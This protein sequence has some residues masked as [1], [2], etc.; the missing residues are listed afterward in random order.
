MLDSGKIMHPSIEARANLD[1]GYQFTAMALVVAGEDLPG[2]PLTEIVPLMFNE[3]MAEEVCKLVN[4]ELVCEC[5]KTEVKENMSTTTKNEAISDHKKVQFMTDCLNSGKSQT[6]CEV[7]CEKQLGSAP[8]SNQEAVMATTCPQCKTAL[9][10]TGMCPNK[11]CQMNKT[12]LPAD[13]NETLATKDRQIAELTEYKAD[14]QKEIEALKEA[15]SKEKATVKNRD[16]RLRQLEESVRDRDKRI[17]QFEKDTDLFRED[18]GKLTQA[19]E[20]AI[21]E[22]NEALGKAA[23]D[24]ERANQE[25]TAR[26]SIQRECGDL[27][28][29]YAKVT[30]EYA[31]L[32]LKRSDDAKTISGLQTESIGYK[33]D[34]QQ[35]TEALEAKAKECER[36]D[37][38]LK[39]AR[40]IFDK[41]GIREVNHEG[42]LVSPV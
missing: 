38:L 30:R 12:Q 37:F 31:D 34:L 33:T 24:A 25:I 10:A 21:S 7:L 35:K 27:R 39:K 4:G 2:D 1:G 36:V 28:E 22:K 8:A 20:T 14:A 32:T 26:A 6:E 16:G 19:R 5:E 17:D 23:K 3:S 9:D 40:K 42:N 13:V 18:I 11:N 29:S 15:I 41:E